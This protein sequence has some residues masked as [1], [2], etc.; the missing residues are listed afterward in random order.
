M[1]L[2]VTCLYVSCLVLLTYE[3][4]LYELHAT[5]LQ[6]VEYLAYSNVA[7]YYRYS[8]QTQKLSVLFYVPPYTTRI[9][10]ARALFV[11]KGQEA[12]NRKFS[13]M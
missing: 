11:T 3:L 9:L 5:A 7:D 2:K 12:L 13:T 4:R 1:C 10:I 6:F 8:T